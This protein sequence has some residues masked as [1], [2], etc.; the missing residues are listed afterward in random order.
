[1]M[2]KVAKEDI[3]TRADVIRLVDTFYD[4]VRHDGLLSPI[5]AHVDWPAH[6]PVMYNFWSSLLFGDQS[7]NGSPFM[8]HK[9]LAIDQS[10]FA[11]WLELFTETVD[12]DFAGER[13]SELKQ[14]AHS[15]AA[16][17]QYKLGLQVK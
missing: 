5:F 1:M 16:M 15:I 3:A 9:G 8:P 7:Y 17:F 14:R 2:P 13:A 4:K 11:R 12:R 10:H 6:L